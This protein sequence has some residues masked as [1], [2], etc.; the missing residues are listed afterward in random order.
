MSG[1]HATLPGLLLTSFALAGCEGG[2]DPEPVTVR[3]TLENIASAGAL[4]SAS[5]ET[6][7]V[8]ISPGVWT[9]HVDGAGLF[10]EG[11]PASSAIEAMAEG[12][13]SDELRA[14]L[15]DGKGILA[16]GQYST[17]PKDGSYEDSPLAPGDTVQ[18]EVSARS[19]A[20]LSFVSMFIHSND[21]LFASPPQGLGLGLALDE[22]V[23]ASAEA[24]LWDAGTEVNEE[25]GFG[26]SQPAQGPGGE[27]EGGVVQRIDGADASGYVYP[28][29]ESFAR[30][31]LMRVE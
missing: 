15:M 6:R 17:G 11:E 23:D 13:K 18:F 2:T 28:A 31:T 22:E 26:S 12:G 14:E 25:P 20:R 9:V 30:V 19:D 8:L 1:S 21:V 10:R 16:Q 7:D 29:P 24:G 27:D 3:V 5:G 4:M